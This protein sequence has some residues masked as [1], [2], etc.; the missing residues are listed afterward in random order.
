[1]FQI[2]LN[3]NGT[4]L[5]LQVFSFSGT[6]GLVLLPLGQ[7]INCSISSQENTVQEHPF[8]FCAQAYE[9]GCVDALPTNPS[10]LCSKTCYNH[11]LVI[12]LF[13]SNSGTM[14][15]L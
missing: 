3:L 6:P 9:S 8:L 4:F 1:M 5:G 12:N 7:M 11:E 14:A 15:E 2:T 13:T 10:I